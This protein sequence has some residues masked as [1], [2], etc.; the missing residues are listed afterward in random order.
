MFVSRYKIKAEDQKYF[1][2]FIA[3]PSGPHSPGLQRILNLFRGCAER[4]FGLI[5]LEPYK[6]WVLATIN[7]P[8]I[9][10]TIHKEYEFDNLEDAERA[11]FRLRWEYHTSKNKEA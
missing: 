1:D 4:R 11:I 9:P 7:G 6:K 10:L 2:E 5:M 3:N 8:T